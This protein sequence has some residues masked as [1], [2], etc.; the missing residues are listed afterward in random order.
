MKTGTLSSQSSDKRRSPRALAKVVVR[1][2]MAD[3]IPGV[4]GQ[5][6][7]NGLSRDFS[8]S[9]LALA[10][11]G[12]LKPGQVLK[13]VFEIPGRDKPIRAFSEV[14]WSSAQVN[15]DGTYQSGIH[16]IAV[17]DEDQADLTRF[18]QRLLKA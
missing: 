7:F 16:I 4:H 15:E 11:D 8:G 9:G 6:W 2:Q 3:A 10:T 5:A 1:Y 14:A 12:L 17:K 13:L 18:V